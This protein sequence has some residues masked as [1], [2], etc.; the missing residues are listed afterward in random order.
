MDGLALLCNLFADVPVT[1]ERLR[2]ARVASLSELERA[3]SERLALWLHASVP[4]ARDLLS[5][6]RKLVRR[7]AEAGPLGE[8]PAPVAGLRAPAPPRRPAPRTSHGA[9]GLALRPGLFPGL[10]EGACSRL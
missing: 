8:V 9:G 3:A 6:A 4:R 10:D 5:E 2:A 7:L 1:L